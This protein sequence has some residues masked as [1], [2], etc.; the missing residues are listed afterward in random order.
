MAE[1]L[2]LEASATTPQELRD[3]ISKCMVDKPDKKDL[4]ALRDYVDLHPGILSETAG[5]AKLVRAQLT[6]KIFEQRALETA[7]IDSLAEIRRGLN[8]DNSPQLERLIIENI[9]N[10]WLRVGYVEMQLSYLAG[11]EVTYTRIEFWEKRLSISQRRFMR[12][13]ETLAKVRKL[14]VPV[15][16]FNIAQ[17]GGQQVNV[18]QM[19]K[20]TP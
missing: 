1:R 20:N 9:E 4:A 5:L 18:G 13:V 11:E 8:Y 12:A 10:C 7:T 14:A 6:S 15:V 17:D 3:L 16:Q 2:R 19:N